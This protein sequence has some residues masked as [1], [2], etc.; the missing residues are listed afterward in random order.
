MASTCDNIIY[1]KR[2]SKTNIPFSYI[3]NNISD[4]RILMTILMDDWKHNMVS[5][6]SAKTSILKK[7][8]IIS[9]SKVIMDLNEKSQF[10]MLSIYTFITK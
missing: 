1:F 4:L 5:H 9:M 7:N 6:E 2:Q 10:Y 3:P 8:I